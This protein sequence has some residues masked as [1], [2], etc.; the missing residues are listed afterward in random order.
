MRFFQ[1]IEPVYDTEGNI[2]GDETFVKSETEII[3]DYYPYWKEQ[4]IKKYGEEVFNRDYTDED[5]IEDWIVI[6]WAEEF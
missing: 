5:C 3:R 2:C 6:N 4:M 1:Y